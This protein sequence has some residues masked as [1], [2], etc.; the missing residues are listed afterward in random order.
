MF[1]FYL[2]KKDF[3]PT[4]L[5]NLKMTSFRWGYYKIFEPYN[6]DFDC[7]KK[8]LEFQFK[9][10]KEMHRI[11]G[12]LDKIYLETQNKKYRGKHC[13]YHIKDMDQLIKHIYYD[14]K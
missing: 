11:F 9:D 10:D 2:Q 6:K 1:T 3:P 12:T 7:L 4:G 13:H 5:K 14:I 8:Y